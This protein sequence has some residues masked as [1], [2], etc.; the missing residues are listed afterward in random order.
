MINQRIIPLILLDGHKAIITRQFKFL[1]YIG[2][3]RTL[4]RLYS[5][6]NADEIIVIQVN[7]NFDVVD[8]INFLR[9][10]SNQTQCPISYGGNLQS[11]D[12][13]SLLI[14]S[15][16]EK[17]IFRSSFFNNPS[18]LTH[19]SSRFGSQAVILGL[20]IKII[21]KVPTF[22]TYSDPSISL[23]F[24][25]IY[26]LDNSDFFGEFFFNM[27]DADGTFTLA[28]WPSA[29]LTSLRKPVIYS[30]GLSRS[31]PSHFKSTC[32]AL[33]GLAVGAHFAFANRNK[34][35]VMPSITSIQ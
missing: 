26:E 10:L 24:S 2:D 12:Q 11:F 27:P 35:S 31:L 30:G 32:S 34:R 6:Q 22:G 16:F 3:P 19:V 14:A 8:N 25:T 1:S 13:A 20:D 7:R 23:D 33:D 4:A 29:F 15:G 17:L 28:Q 5:D 9:S 21:A 18:L